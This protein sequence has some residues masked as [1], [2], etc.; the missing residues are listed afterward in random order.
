MLCRI[1]KDHNFITSHKAQ[2]LARPLVQKFRIEVI[3]PQAV[4]FRL[5]RQAVGSDLGRKGLELSQ[6]VIQ[7]THGQQTVVALNDVI[8]EV[9]RGQQQDR[10]VQSPA[11]PVTQMFDQPHGAIESCTSPSVKKKSYEIQ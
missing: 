2:N 7:L 4:G 1:E 10:R 9:D 11:G 8:H 3:G 6:L 5:K